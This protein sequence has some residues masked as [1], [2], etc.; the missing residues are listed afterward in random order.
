MITI[1]VILKASLVFAVVLVG[2]A[3]SHAQHEK[4]DKEVLFF[5][6]SFFIGVGETS[7]FSSVSV[8]GGMGYFLTRKHEVGGT[9]N[10]NLF[11]FRLCS[12]TID[13]DGNVI[14]EDCDS[15]TDFS[16]GLSGFYRY[17]FAGKDDR[18]FPFIGGEMSVLDVTNNFT[19]NVKGRAFLGYKYYVKK[20]VALDFTVG[21]SFDINKVNERFFDSDRGGNIDGRFGL[22]FIF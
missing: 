5:S 9:L 4:G 21:Y 1:K 16:G 22:S 7:G 14:S 10:A 20:N 13:P 8:G 18:S 11:R 3:S 6:G 17:N 12:R 2:S 19:G 15:D